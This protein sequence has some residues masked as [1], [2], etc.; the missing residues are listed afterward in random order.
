MKESQISKFLSSCVS[1]HLEEGELT[2]TELDRY[3]LKFHNH[4]V[5]TFEDLWKIKDFDDFIK[6]IITNDLDGFGIFR[7]GIKMKYN[8]FNQEL[9]SQKKK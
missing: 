3:I 4:N 9:E 2:Q 1:D 7:V 6:K 8:D 5:F